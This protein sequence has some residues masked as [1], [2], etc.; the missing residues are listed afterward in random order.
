VF[1]SECGEQVQGKFCWACGAKLAPAADAALATDRDVVLE[2]DWSNLVDYEALIRVSDVRDRIARSAARSKKSMTG[3]QFLDLCDKAMGGGFGIPMST[4]AHFAQGLHAK[5]G[6]KTA[7]S[8]SEFLS[9]RP[10]TVLV[11]LLC[12]LAT[13]G[14]EVREAHQLSD[15]CIVKAVLPSD[16]FALEGALIVGVSRQAGG[17][18]IEARTEIAGQM[19]DW[20]KSSR[21]LDELFRELGDSMAA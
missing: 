8:R 16:M 3:E 19:F 2:L 21:C 9:Q 11:A 18:R 12:S 15:G 17:T 6:I 10:G 20:G 14:R 13:H 4:I 5:L 1:C 7:K